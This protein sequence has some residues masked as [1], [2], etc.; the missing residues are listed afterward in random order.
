MSVS[1]R[2][3]LR[4]LL[5][6]AAL[7]GCTAAPTTD[8]GADTDLPLPEV[9]LD[10]APWVM[11]TG[12]TQVRLR[13]ETLADVAVAVWVSGPGNAARSLTPTRTPS[14]L[15]Y[16]N[17]TFS[18]ARPAD[19]PGLHVLHELTLDA[20]VPGEV[21]AWRVP[22]ATATYEGAF[23]CPPAPD[24]A[25]RI[26]WMADTMWPNTDATITALTAQSP[27]VI[28]H[29]GDL[30]YSSNPSD[31]WR[32]LFA[33]LV[34]VTAV[35][36]LQVTV[37][38]H[39][40]EKE[41]ELSQMFDR[42]FAGQGEASFERAHRFRAGSALVIVLDSESFDLSDASNAQYDWLDEQLD[43]ADADPT[44]KSVIL[45][46]HRPLF[47]FSEHYHTSRV[48]EDTMVPHLTGHPKVR[49]VLGGHSHSFEH[50]HLYDIDWIVDGSAGALLYDVDENLPTATDA[51][52]DLVAG[53]LHAEAAYGCCT[54]DVAPD[55]SMVVRR[56]LAEDG[57][58]SYRLEIPA[59]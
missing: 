49:L 11:I 10:K 41:D 37:G 25:V 48:D 50:F 12:P 21:Y 39:E 40:L 1:R 51:R 59:V 9:E 20:L 38:N 15:T 34:P 8:D 45:A 4:G 57:S 47:T 52:P 43:A 31:T 19:V 56:L 33:S 32:G 30:Q 14:E 28:V 17:L 6:G 22:T 42:L 36:P 27:D 55:G 53:R 7:A 18:D 13:F 23:R 29:G 16:E 3:V 54:I 26:G 58:E 2:D 44:V 35:A 46:W 5:G 24:A